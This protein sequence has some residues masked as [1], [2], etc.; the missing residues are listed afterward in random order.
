ML[1]KQKDRKVLQRKLRLMISFRQIASQT[2]C[3]ETGSIE[4]YTNYVQQFRKSI[5]NL[6]FFQNNLGIEIQILA[7]WKFRIELCAAENHEHFNRWYLCICSLAS[8]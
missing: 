3:V 2:M 6:Y 1:V 8:I 5:N 7:V 4:V